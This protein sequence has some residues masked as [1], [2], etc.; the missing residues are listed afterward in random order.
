MVTSTRPRDSRAPICLLIDGSS[1]DNSPPRRRC[2]SRKRLFTVLRSTETAK[3]SPS[4]APRPYPVIDFITSR[5]DHLFFFIGELQFIQ[6]AVLAATREQFRVGSHL[7]D[8]SVLHHHNDVCA[9]YR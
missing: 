5:S 6:P 2:T 8:S 4:A 3:F 1:E 9:A 7:N